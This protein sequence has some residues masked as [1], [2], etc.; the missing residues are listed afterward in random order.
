MLI[1]VSPFN[2]L[3]LHVLELA[4]V[5]FIARMCFTHTFFIVFLLQ[6]Y[7]FSIFNRSFLLC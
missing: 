2:Y 6:N 5:L 3:Y 1:F 4:C 7:Y